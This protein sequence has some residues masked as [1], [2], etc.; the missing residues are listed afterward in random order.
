LEKQLRG[1]NASLF[2]EKIKDV[3]PMVGV[4]IG[5]TYPNVKM[6]EPFKKTKR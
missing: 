6:E 2:Q 4:R 3:Q 5:A 1:G